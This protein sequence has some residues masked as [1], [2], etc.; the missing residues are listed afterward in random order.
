VR[1]SRR[2][3]CTGACISLFEDVPWGTIGAVYTV[4]TASM[5]TMKAIAVTGAKHS[6]SALNSWRHL[7]RQTRVFLVFASVSALL[8]TA[9]IAADATDRTTMPDYC[10]ERD[11][12]CVLLDGPSRVIAA[13]RT[14]DPSGINTVITLPSGLPGPGAVGGTLAPSVPTLT[15]PAVPSLTGP[16]PSLTTGTT[17]SNATSGASSSA[18]RPA[19]SVGPASKR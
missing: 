16:V 18:G 8:P 13:P 3:V 1:R 7:M 6:K 19:A 4:K 14:A 15:G 9:L 10:S 2:A 12:N 17:P 5:S 11:V